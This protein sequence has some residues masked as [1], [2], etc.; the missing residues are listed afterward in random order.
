M[1]I[2]CRSRS[3]TCSALYSRVSGQGGR[4]P[5]VDYRL[6]PEHPFPAGLLGVLAREVQGAG[7]A[8]ALARAAFFLSQ[9]LSAA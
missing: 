2:P 8:Q 3:G 9:H 7:A 5:A 6:A 4:A 1:T